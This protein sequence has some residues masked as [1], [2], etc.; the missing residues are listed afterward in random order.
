[1]CEKLKYDTTK[2]YE[3]IR[4][5]RVQLQNGK[6]GIITPTNGYNYLV[7]LDNEKIWHHH[8][9]I[10]YYFREEKKSEVKEL[11]FQTLIEIEK[12]LKEK[13][14]IIVRL[15]RHGLTQALIFDEKG[16]QQYQGSYFGAMCWLDRLKFWQKNYA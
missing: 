9:T 7:E 2:W 10:D 1:M 14:N 16:A 11:T 3:L 4:G 13:F 12:E 15:E 6:Q 5:V 8:T